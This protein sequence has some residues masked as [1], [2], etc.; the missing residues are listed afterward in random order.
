MSG[1]CNPIPLKA[2]VTSD[3]VIITEADVAAG[4]RYFQQQ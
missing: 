2:T 4:T 1:G 3:T